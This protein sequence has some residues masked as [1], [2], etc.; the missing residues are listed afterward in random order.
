MEILTIMV[1]R[2][3]AKQVKC[4]GYK[5]KVNETSF[6]VFE[7]KKHYNNIVELEISLFRLVNDVLRE[8][9][10]ECDYDREEYY[11]EEKYLFNPI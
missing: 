6:L 11:S 2:R 7:S 4:E 10:Y 5:I 9:E 3:T 1:G 8:Y